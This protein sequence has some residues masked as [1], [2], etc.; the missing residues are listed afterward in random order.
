MRLRRLL[1]V[2]IALLAFVLPGLIAAEESPLKPPLEARI[3]LDKDI[4]AVGDRVTISG[5]ITNSSSERVTIFKKLRGYTIGHLKMSDE[6]D[7][8]LRGIPLIKLALHPDAVE[9][10][11]ELAPGKGITLT[12]PAT[13]RE[14][15]AYDI[16]TGTKNMRGLFLN[17]GTS[18]ITI[19]EKGKY[20]MRFEFAVNQMLRDGWAK[21]F[22]FQNLWYGTIVSDPVVLTIK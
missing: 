12:F 6:V 19:P 20:E 10:F 8:P 16:K 9:D 11:T 1:V 5:I 7:R 15:S 22:G 21:I 3:S 14:E 13:L 4:I 18:S 17:F 2:A